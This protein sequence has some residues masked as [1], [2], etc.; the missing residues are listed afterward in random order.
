VYL[1]WF[2]LNLL[3]IIKIKVMKIFK[4]LV[5]PLFFIFALN[6]CGTV[7]DAFSMQKKDNTDEFLVEKKNPLKLPPNFDELPL[8]NSE[9]TLETSNSNKEGTLED[10]IINTDKNS[11]NSKKSNENVGETLEELLLGKIKNK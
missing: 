4:V 9:N 1:L 6:S 2:Y 3:V 5:L 7:K 11:Q 10:L 8:P